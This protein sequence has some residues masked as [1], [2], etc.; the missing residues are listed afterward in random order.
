LSRSFRASEFTAQTRHSAKG[1]MRNEL[2]HSRYN[3]DRNSRP[4]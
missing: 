3:D 2:A 1:F 4:G